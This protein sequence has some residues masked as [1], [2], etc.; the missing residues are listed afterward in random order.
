V[1]LGVG[2]VITTDGYTDARR[3]ASGGIIVGIDGL[4]LLLVAAAQSCGN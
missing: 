2:W 3:L 4:V 1:A